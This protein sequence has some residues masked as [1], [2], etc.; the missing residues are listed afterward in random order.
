MNNEGLAMTGRYARQHGARRRPPRLPTRSTLG[1]CICC[2]SSRKSS[3]SSKTPHASRSCEGCAESGPPTAACVS[4]GD[5]TGGDADRWEGG[6]GAARRWNGPW[7]HE[8]E[9]WRGAR[10]ACKA[11]SSLEAALHQP[12]RGAPAAH[13]SIS[14]GLPVALGA[15]A[16]RAPAAGRSLSAGRLGATA[17]GEL[18]VWRSKG[19][20]KGTK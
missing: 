1:E 20:S 9:G 3:S 12:L 7:E 2:S 8:G 11:W 14:K 18:M 19:G 4:A 6:G 16:G 13:H 10:E 15:S 17:A 5:G